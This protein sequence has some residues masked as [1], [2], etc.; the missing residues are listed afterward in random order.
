MQAHVKAMLGI[1]N[2]VVCDAHQNSPGKRVMIRPDAI[3]LGEEA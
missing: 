2:V 3:A 1:V